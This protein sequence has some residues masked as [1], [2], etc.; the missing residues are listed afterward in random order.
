MSKILTTADLAKYL[1]LTQDTI[2]EYRSLEAHNPSIR[3]TLLPPG[4]RMGLRGQWRYRLSDIDTWI[5][6]RSQQALVEAS[7]NASDEVG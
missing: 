1:R 5:A 4:F 6:D 7:G 3:G 2:R